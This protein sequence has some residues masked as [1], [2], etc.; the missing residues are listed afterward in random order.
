MSVYC[1][2]AIF[3]RLEWNIFASES[4]AMDVVAVLVVVDVSAMNALSMKRQPKI[5]VTHTHTT[6]SHTFIFNSIFVGRIENIFIVKF[7]E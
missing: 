2:S 6:H 3:F 4:L 7:V 5:I 1:A